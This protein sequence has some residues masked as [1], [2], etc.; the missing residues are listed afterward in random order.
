MLENWRIC[1]DNIRI[2]NHHVAALKHALICEREQILLKF[3]HS[4]IITLKRHLQEDVN[5]RLPSSLYQS[6]ELAYSENTLYFSLNIY[7]R[8]LIHPQR[9]PY[10]HSTPPK[11]S[12]QPRSHYSS[13]LSPEKT[14]SRASISKSTMTLL[15]SAP[16][17]TETQEENAVQRWWQRLLLSEPYP[18]ISDSGLHKLEKRS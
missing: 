9:H 18:K 11:P 13:V 8:T 1:I 3:G 4:M 14:I 12:E 15:F 7:I 10:P 6:N 5:I 2:M 17:K 16:A